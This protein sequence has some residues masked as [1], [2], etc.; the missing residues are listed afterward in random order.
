M[1][2]HRRRLEPDAARKKLATFSLEGMSWQTLLEQDEANREAQAYAPQGVYARDPRDD[3]ITVFN[4]RRM[5]RPHDYPD[6]GADTSSAAAKSTESSCPIC[7]ANTTPIIDLKELSEGFTFINRNLY[8]IVAPQAPDDVQIPAAPGDPQAPAAPG[9][10]AH[11]GAAFGA[12]FLQW[13]SSYHDR[14]WPELGEADRTTVMERLARLEAVLLHLPDFPG[15]PTPA[16]APASA[17]GPASAPAEEPAPD[18]VPNDQRR[19]D[20]HVSIIKNVGRTVGGSLSHGHQQITLSNVLPGRVRE[21]Q[22]FERRYGKRFA[23]FMHE[24]NPEELTVAQLETGKL[25]VPYFMRRPYDMQY[26]PAS[27]SGEYLSDLSSAQLRDLAGG[28]A[29]GMQALEKVLRSLGKEI[30][31]NV[32]FHTGPGAGVYL[33]LLPRTQE[34]GGYEQLGLSACQAIP[35]RAAEVLREAV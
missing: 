2:E 23:P 19:D 20:R 4:E 22:Q 35:A 6:R 17:P 10:K 13:T 21:H 29:I 11:S 26:L 34:N 9:H 32:L 3:T 25:I 14:D 28:L 1:G 16:S 27:V 24:N 7:A 30:A 31:Y 8:P 5:S 12:H 33:E 18:H 15:G